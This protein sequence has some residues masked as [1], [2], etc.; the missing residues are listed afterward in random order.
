MNTQPTKTGWL[1]MV[2][3]YRRIE[4]DGYAHLCPLRI[5]V[6]YG[7]A[8]EQAVL[9]KLTKQGFSDGRPSPYLTSVG[10]EFVCDKL[11]IIV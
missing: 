6:N 7:P 3:A 5:N 2:T 4:R 10:I 11:R 9:N 8:V 1:A